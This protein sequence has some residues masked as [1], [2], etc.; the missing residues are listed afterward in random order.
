VRNLK[1]FGDY[2]VDLGNI[3]QPFKSAIKLLIGI[4]KT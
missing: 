1:R 2:F 3:P 4:P